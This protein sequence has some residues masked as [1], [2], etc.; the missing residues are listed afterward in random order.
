MRW[1]LI[2]PASDI[3]YRYH[4]HWRW[5]KPVEGNSFFSMSREWLIRLQQPSGITCTQSTS[6][7]LGIFLYLWEVFLMGI[8]PQAKLVHFCFPLFWSWCIYGSCFTRTGHP[9]SSLGA[10]HLWRP[11]KVTFLTPSPCP[12]ASTWAG[13]P[14]APCGCPHTVD[15]KHTPLFWND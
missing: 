15:M 2:R 8:Q 14:S 12:H 9:W 10:I 11:K 6:F 5:S 4:F 3:I 7:S 1:L 13:P